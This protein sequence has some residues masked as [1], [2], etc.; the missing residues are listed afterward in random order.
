MTEF[1]GNLATVLDSITM[2]SVV[3]VKAF[4]KAI[5]VSSGNYSAASVA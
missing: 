3:S 1:L 5:V 2:C 4:K